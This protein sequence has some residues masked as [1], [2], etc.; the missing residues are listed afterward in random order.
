MQENFDIY[1][2]L[3]RFCEESRATTRRTLKRFTYAPKNDMLDGIS[4][5]F[6]MIIDLENYDYSESSREEF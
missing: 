5:V 3:R 6:S 4:D 2:K 1:L